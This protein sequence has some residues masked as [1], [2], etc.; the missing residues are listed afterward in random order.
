MWH[1]LSFHLPHHPFA[2]TSVLTILL[3]L[4]H[5][6]H[7]VAKKVIVTPSEWC[8]GSNEKEAATSP[9]RVFIDLGANWANTIRLWK[10]IGCCPNPPPGA[11]P[12]EVFFFEASP[13]MADFN[14]RM[15]QWLNGNSSHRPVQPILS[16]GSTKD[17]IRAYAGRF[18]CNNKQAL[19]GE[20]I[21]RATFR[22]I[23]SK[24]DESIDKAI[25]DAR[26]HAHVFNT[27]NFVAQALRQAVHPPDP[28]RMRPR[29]VFVPSAAGSAPGWIHMTWGRGSYLR[30]GGRA[31][32]THSSP[33]KPPQPDE[34]FVVRV[35]DVVDWMIRSF[36]SEDWIVLKMDIEGAEHE[37]LESLL[38]RKSAHL[39]DILAWEC[40]S[41]PTTPAAIACP[42]LRS[43]L[44]SAGVNK[45]ITETKEYNGM[46]A[47]CER[48]SMMQ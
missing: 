6:D 29:Y 21:L 28:S 45:I 18:G 40:H 48:E 26:T 5:T 36:A 27:T 10:E 31:T 7:A 37:L 38:R 39:I 34:D 3:V 22:C 23:L 42:Q 46:D 4:V 15:A 16:A 13:I 43:R 19:P 41:T 17:T 2:F 1:S 35:I 33:T 20:S 8:H 25:R 44:L 30:G 24:A 12:W 47:D 32:P 9:R 11:R 14:Y